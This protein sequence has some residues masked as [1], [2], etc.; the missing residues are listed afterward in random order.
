MWQIDLITALYASHHVQFYY[1]F[2]CLSSFPNSVLVSGSPTYY[3]Y[4]PLK[5]LCK[6]R[7]IIN[8]KFFHFLQTT[9]SEIYSNC[10]HNQAI[11]CCRK[12]IN[13][14]FWNCLEIVNRKVY[15]MNGSWFIF[16][17]LSRKL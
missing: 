1:Y 11:F 9:V 15:G 13:V 5:V 6:I 14:E 10:G 16:Q 12:Q 7:D 8:A 4:V 3:F 2:S 17:E